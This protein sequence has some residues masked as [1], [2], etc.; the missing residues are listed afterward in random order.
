[1]V[2]RESPVDT[3]PRGASVNRYSV[4]TGNCNIG[5]NVLVSQ[6]AFIE[7]AW[8]GKGANAQENCYISHSRLE[9]YNVTAH[10]A[11][12]IY[13]NLG[14]KVFVGFNSFLQGKADCPLTIGDESIVMP[15]TIIDLVEPV[16]VPGNHLVWGHI[17]TQQD[18]A[19][20]SI[21]LD[22]LARITDRVEVGNMRFKGSG[23]A[24]VAAFRHRINHILEENG[25]FYDG[26][27][28]RGH[29]QKGQNIAFNIIQPYPH[30]PLKGLYPTIDMAP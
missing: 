9:G 15:H 5:E 18:L 24:F 22:K 25:A 23:E 16:T 6:R 29:A 28:G 14:L 27:Y 20:N 2:H 13:A 1:V 11:T 19:E 12:I 10:G 3:V 17:R 4:V 30:G 21:R 7:E 8:L 26:E